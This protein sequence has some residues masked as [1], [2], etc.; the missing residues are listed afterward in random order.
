MYKER[1]V[2]R[3]FDEDSKKLKVEN[4]DFF[5]R[6]LACANAIF[7][8][9]FKLCYDNGED[10][11]NK[12]NPFLSQKMKLEFTSLNPEIRFSGKKIND[13]IKN[14]KKKTDIIADEILKVGL[15]TDDF[16]LFLYEN[17]GRLSRV[18]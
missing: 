10:K 17:L 9:F 2:G 4:F 13:R 5:T 7:N 16:H 14:N 1:P 18:A 12:F 6:Y 15:I 11:L 3:Y 8:P